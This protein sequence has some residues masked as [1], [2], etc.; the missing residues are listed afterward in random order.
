M[1]IESAHINLL[2]AVRRSNAQ[3]GGAQANNGAQTEVGG[4]DAADFMADVALV[5]DPKGTEG[6]GGVGRRDLGEWG[7]EAGVDE[8]V[9]DEE[10]EKAS[11]NAQYYCTHDSHKNPT[12]RKL[13]VEK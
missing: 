9:V 5:G 10:C 13:R 1:L 7:E 8:E 2:Q 3:L 6:G 12:S 4:I 11:H